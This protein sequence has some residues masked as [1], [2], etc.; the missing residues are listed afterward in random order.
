MFRGLT[1]MGSFKNSHGYDDIP[2]M[3]DYVSK[4]VEAIL[5]RKAY[6]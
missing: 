4:L 5:C 6:T 3:V 1:F 2:D